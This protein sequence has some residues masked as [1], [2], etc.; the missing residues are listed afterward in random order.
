MDIA[1]RIGVVLAFFGTGATV[2]AL[3]APYEWRDMPTWAR[4]AGLC[5]GATLMAVG[6][7][8]IF[9]LPH[10]AFPDVRLI[11]VQGDTPSLIIENQSPTKTALSIK[12]GGLLANVTGED[13]R[14]PL[15]IPFESFDFLRPTGRSALI[16]IFERPLV[17]PLLKPEDEIFG[18]V[19]VS[20]PE[21][22]R[23]RIYWLYIRWTKGG[24]YS[25][26]PE[27]KGIDTR[28]LYQALPEIKQNSTVALR[29][30][31]ASARVPIEKPK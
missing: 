11:F 29:F 30:I 18:Y 9:L 22:V 5:S 14:K 7:L 10:E 2:V 16:P 17:T 15:P 20:C 25:E 19:A 31:P 28:W 8:L 26:V 13:P 4:R 3:F 12:Y 24:W 1:T 6:V 21:C 23:E 27:G